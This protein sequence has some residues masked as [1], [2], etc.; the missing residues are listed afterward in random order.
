MNL[1]LS[2]DG[3]L[4]G[5]F[6]ALKNSMPIPSWMKAEYSFQYIYACQSSIKAS[7]GTPVRIFRVRAGME[8]WPS[9]PDRSSVDSSALEEHEKVADSS[10][11]RNEQKN[12]YFGRSH[13][14]NLKIE[15]RSLHQ[16]ISIR[17]HLNI[18]GTEIWK[19]FLKGRDI[20]EHLN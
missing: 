4:M 10:H 18:A 7:N 11:L 12:Y 3:H 17:L 5:S 1:R 2:S 9:H 6:D 19:G 15:D 13:K 8:N 16:S 14:G 20:L